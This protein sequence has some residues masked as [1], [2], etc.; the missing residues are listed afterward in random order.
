MISSDKFFYLVN[1]DILKSIEDLT[2]YATMI[3][4]FVFYHHV[5]RERN[6]FYNWIKDVFNDYELANQV[7]GIFTKEQFVEFFNQ[8]KTSAQN[9]KQIAELMTKLNETRVNKEEKKILKEFKGKKE[10]IENEI[11]DS[12]DQK[13]KEIEK[14][15][16]ALNTQIDDSSK[17]ISDLRKKGK[18]VFLCQ[19]YYDIIK[20]KQKIA[21]FSLDEKDIDLLEVLDNKLEQE[22]AFVMSNEEID[23]RKEIE[24]Q[25]LN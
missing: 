4:D 22:I 14:K 15:I 10:N 9:I 23:I 18:D 1:G 24:K 11:T 17:R 7:K 5:S 19:I 12:R 16:N 3:P 13:H 8:K 21:S 25:S 20:A 2:N 6:D